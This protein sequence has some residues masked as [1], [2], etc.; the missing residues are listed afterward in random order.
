MRREGF[1]ET[2]DREAI[3]A[4]DIDFFDVAA[5]V[6]GGVSVAE[7]VDSA[8]DVILASFAFISLD[9]VTAIV[10]ILA[11]F[12]FDVSDDV[13]ISADSLA[14]HLLIRGIL[15]LLVNSILS[16]A[17]SEVVPFRTKTAKVFTPSDL[18]SS[19]T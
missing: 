7:D 5:G 2:I 19:R 10:V 14:S 17:S 9:V 11:D 16:A 13:S 3:S 15:F 4:Q 1:G 8:T 6:G 12:A 18:L